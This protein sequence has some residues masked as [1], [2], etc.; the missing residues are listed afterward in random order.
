M[1]AVMGIWIGILGCFCLMIC[2]FIVHDLKLCFV[3]YAVVSVDQTDLRKDVA[4]PF[5]R[6]FSKSQIKAPEIA[7][8]KIAAV[9]ADA[10]VF[11]APKSKPFAIVSENDFMTASGFV[12]AKKEP[13]LSVAPNL[14]SAAEKIDFSSNPVS[15]KVD[16]T[17]PKPTMLSQDVSASA[18]NHSLNVRVSNVES[19]SR[20]SPSSIGKRSSEHQNENVKRPK[21]NDIST[22][23]KRVKISNLPLLVSERS[24]IVE[25]QSCGTIWFSFAFPVVLFQCDRCHSRPKLRWSCFY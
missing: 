6:V 11:V 12:P 15:Q 14:S 9:A 8:S 21:L 1:C 2:V 20:S 19:E 24:L 22:H 13:T 3:Y 18:P 7:K 16:I 25:L 5:N 17:E 23:L 10:S 4:K